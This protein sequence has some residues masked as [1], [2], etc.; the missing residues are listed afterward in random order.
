MEFTPIK[1]N[2]SYEPIQVLPKSR[3]ILWL[4]DYYTEWHTSNSSKYRLVIHSLEKKQ[5]WGGGEDWIK[6][7]IK[8]FWFINI[9]FQ[10]QLFCLFSPH[11]STCLLAYAPSGCGDASASLCCRLSMYRW[12]LCAYSKLGSDN[13]ISDTTNLWLKNTYCSCNSSSLKFCEKAEKQSAHLVF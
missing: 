4:T 3:N 7:K 2:R 13:C 1:K 9:V 12:A 11:C 6:N 8:K 5:C 10:H